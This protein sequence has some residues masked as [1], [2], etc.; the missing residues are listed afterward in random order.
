[1]TLTQ[2]RKGTARLTPQPKPNCH[3]GSQRSQKMKNINAC[4]R[5]LCVPLRQKFCLKCSI[6]RNSTAKTQR[7]FRGGAY[8]PLPA[9]AGN[10]VPALPTMGLL[11]IYCEGHW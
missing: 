2:K 11:H 4:L 8:N 1:M 5:V 3:E 7:G 10:G 6:L 9:A